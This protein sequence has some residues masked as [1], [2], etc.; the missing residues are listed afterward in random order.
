MTEVRPGDARLG[1][2]AIAL[3]VL[4]ALLVCVVVLSILPATVIGLSESVRS[5]VKQVFPEG[6]PLFTRDPAAAQFR[7]ATSENGEWTWRDR[8][9][10]AHPSNFGGLNKIAIARNVEIA[11]LVTQL[12][13]LQRWDVCNGQPLRCLRRANDSGP[14]V[15]NDREDPSLCGTVGF[16]Y[17]EPVPWTRRGK[18]NGPGASRVLIAE[19]ECT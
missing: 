8:G 6:W 1:W 18:V 4:S 12:P 2:L 17:Q 19:V 13:R 5:D 10:L 9:P 3:G 11:L 15:T 7:A 16:V 14:T